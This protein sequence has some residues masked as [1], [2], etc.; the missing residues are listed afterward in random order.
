MGLLLGKNVMA[1]AGFV[2][3]LLP[4]EWNAPAIAQT[5][6]DTVGIAD[7][8][9]V[10]RRAGTR[11]S[12]TFSV[13]N[14]TPCPVTVFFDWLE[15]RV[16][17]SILPYEPRNIPVSTSVPV[18][19]TIGWHPYTPPCYPGVGTYYH[20]VKVI[21]NSQE[22]KMIVIRED[23]VDPDPLCE[24]AIAAEYDGFPLAAGMTLHHGQ[25]MNFTTSWTCQCTFCESECQM[26]NLWEYSM[27][28]GAT[29]QVFHDA[30]YWGEFV[31]TIPDMPTTG[32]HFRVTGSDFFGLPFSDTIGPFTIV[33]DP[34]TCC[35]GPT[36]NVDARDI[37]DIGDLSLLI[38][39]LIKPPGTVT[40]PCESEA[41]IDLEG[42]ID[43]SDLSYLV[44]YLTAANQY[45]PD[46]P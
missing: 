10:T 28:G 31:F 15:A 39:Y 14:T 16:D 34:A 8:I 9:I 12:A 26:P 46:C 19:V 24:V 43:L 44:G 30:G 2:L 7:T 41:N 3:V 22:F 38:H 25:A 32:A 33:A 21:V 35:E 18:T 20:S 6:E 13:T 4:G 37:V 40:V 29:W 42:T 11:D 5:C 27:D 23:V 1:V 36:G 17:F 45:L